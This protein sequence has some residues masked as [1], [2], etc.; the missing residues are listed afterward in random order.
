MM[1]I[2]VGPDGSGKST[3]AKQLS[4]QTGYPIQHRSKPKDQAEKDAMMTMYMDLARTGKNVILDRAW[5]CEMVYGKVMRDKSYIST[6]QMHELEELLAANGGGLIIH[7][8]DTIENL[9]KRCSERGEDYIKNINDLAAIK[10]EYGWIMNHVP[11]HIP[12]VQYRIR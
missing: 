3:L 7:C 4:A 8:T 10:M 2:I 11:H 12:M 1:I 5:Y 6:E 9:W